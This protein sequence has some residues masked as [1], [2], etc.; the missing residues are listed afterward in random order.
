M[1]K[2]Y[3]IGTSSRVDQARSHKIEGGLGHLSMCS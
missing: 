1:T 2:A 3:L